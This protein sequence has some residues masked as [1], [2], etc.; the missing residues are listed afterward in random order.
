MSLNPKP[1]PPLSEA[2]LSGP[3]ES[4]ER[5]SI[6]ASPVTA[7]P[8]GTQL[9]ESRSYL[10]TNWDRYLVRIGALL[11]AALGWHL[12]STYGF[13]FFVRFENVPG[14]LIVG[15]EF[16]AQ[17]SSQEFY[18]HILHS[19]QRIAMA[20]GLA[21]VI[22]VVLGVMMGRSRF[23]EDVILPYIE[24]LRPIPAVAWIPLA[25]LMM[26]S[27]QSSIVFIT[28]LGALFPIVINT[29]HGVDQTPKMLVRAARSL[30][31]SN[32]AILWHV[33]L[34]GALPSI[35]AGL[36]IGM[37]VAWFSLLAGEIISGQ[38]GIGYFTWSAYTLVEYPKI[39]IG[40]LVIGGL[41][42]LCTLL[43]RKA[44]SPLLRWQ[45]EGAKS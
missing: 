45:T 17:A 22:G 34:P 1:H 19:M 8:A 35:V 28:F 20:Y 36:A 7:T 32:A 39:I 42:S 16:L 6:E 43:V 26:P 5:P 2:V 41:G 13:D 11:V 40:M 3:L 27:E 14:P 10:P 25:I 38:Y 18:V 24:I 30:G 15:A 12:A 44:C 21:V 23:A 31:A 4:S 29:V 9:G 33:V 37:G